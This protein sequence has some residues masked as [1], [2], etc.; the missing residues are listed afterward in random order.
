MVSEQ[1]TSPKRTV[2][3]RS[4]GGK[5]LG[6]IDS[7]RFELPGISG[8]TSALVSMVKGR[9]AGCFSMLSTLISLLLPTGLPLYLRD[10]GW[11]PKNANDFVLSVGGMVLGMLS[12]VTWIRL[13]DSLPYNK[14]RVCV[15]VKG[16]GTKGH[17]TTRASAFDPPVP[18]EQR[19]DGAR[20]EAAIISGLTDE[21]IR[22]TLLAFLPYLPD[23]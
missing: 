19:L 10:I 6:Y 4:S 15:T 16:Q 5:P 7:G 23:T 20:S 22:R 14:G 21:E 9:P 12:L 1:P 13:S 18:L 11:I 17:K 8:P 3:E 2:I